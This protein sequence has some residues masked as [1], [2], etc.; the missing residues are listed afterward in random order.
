MV[1]T[2]QSEEEKALALAGGP[3]SRH[4]CTWVPTLVGE[5][6]SPLHVPV[7]F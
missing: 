5:L 1:T 3:V 6:D 2:A 7:H 4:I